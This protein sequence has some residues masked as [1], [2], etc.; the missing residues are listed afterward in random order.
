MKTQSGN[1]PKRWTPIGRPFWCLAVMTLFFAATAGA[2]ET[3][4]DVGPALP[5]IELE[6]ALVMAV[7]RNPS[8]KNVDEQIFQADVQI[9]R[10]WSMLLP[11]LDATG[12]VTRQQE[13]KLGFP[14][15]MTINK[16]PD[17][18]LTLNDFATME[19]T[20]TVIQE[21]WGKAFG[22]SA[23]I[24]LFNPRSIPLIKMAYDISN[25]TKLRSQMQKNNLLYAITSS[26]YQVHSL[27]EAIGVRRETLAAAKHFL[28]LSKA[29]HTVGQTTKI[30]VLRAEIQ[31]MDAQ[32]ELDNSIDAHKIAKISLAYLIGQEGDF[33]IVPPNQVELQ[34][35]DREELTRQALQKR[36]EIQSAEFDKTVAERA[37]QDTW[38]KWLPSFDVTYAWNWNSAA[39]FAGDNDTWMLIFGAKWKVFQGGDRIAELKERKSKVRAAKNN[40][41]QLR[42]DIRQEIDQNHQ[43]VIQ[44]ERNMTLADK[45]VTLAEENYTLINR[46][47]EVGVVSSLDLLNASTELATK[48]IS[49][50]LERLQYDIAVL[51]LKKAAG[52]YH[53]LSIVALA[54]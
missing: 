2:E 3:P 4:A 20:E 46:Q 10:A 5:K 8:L 28:R 50:V 29:R 7:E 36:V 44:R 14:D 19:A 41:D 43:Q 22:F 21:K 24:T 40:Q 42:L 30:D 35:R 27:Q 12:S 47:Y 33:E 53:S 34:T 54:E 37:K 17:E 48:R 38:M 18:P 16:P 1:S 6:Q 11:N 49:R 25:Q 52:D 32:K 9:N 23:N 13:I 39:G 31:V 51:K 15:F 45:Q 26:F